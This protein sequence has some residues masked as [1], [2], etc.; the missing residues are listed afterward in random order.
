MLTDFI[1]TLKRLPE[2]LPLPACPLARPSERFWAPVSADRKI[3]DWLK[4]FGI[5]K[6]RPK[7]FS[8]DFGGQMVS[9][10]HARLA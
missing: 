10:R 7:C 4:Q 5:N 1:M 3:T 8:D 2:R 9:A 6:W